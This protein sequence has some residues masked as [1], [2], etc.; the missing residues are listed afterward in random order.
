MM[1][2]HNHEFNSIIHFLGIGYAP[3]GMPTN[4]KKHL[5]VRA[6]DYTLIMGHLYKLATDK[7]LRHC[8]FD[9]EQPW[10]MSE[11]YAGVTGEHYVGKA[12]VRN[13]L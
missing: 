5:V 1:D 12:T 7:V 10:V 2:E 9:Y 13:I 6:A 8:F 3:E 11:A 4:Q